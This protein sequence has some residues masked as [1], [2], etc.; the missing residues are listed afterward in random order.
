MGGQDARH[1]TMK[2]T[3][4]FSQQWIEHRHAGEKLKQANFNT[5]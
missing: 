5:R 1:Q 3:K 4:A 2:R